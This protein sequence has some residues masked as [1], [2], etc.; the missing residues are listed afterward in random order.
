MSR[1]EWNCLQDFSFSFTLILSKK[2]TL[3]RKIVPIV[4]HIAMHEHDDQKHDVIYWLSRP[5]AE[6]IKAVTLLRSQFI[7]KGERMDKT[8]VVK[9]KR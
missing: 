9:R 2:Y 5:P 8:H 6:R 7:E 1:L 3:K 4:R